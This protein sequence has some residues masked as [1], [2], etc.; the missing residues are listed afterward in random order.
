MRTMLVWR[1]AMISEA[2]GVGGCGPA[3]RH[4]RVPETENRKDHASRSI[5]CTQSV[6]IGETENV[7]QQDTVNAT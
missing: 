2:L 5:A 7:P 4:S 1:A 3:P 6:Q